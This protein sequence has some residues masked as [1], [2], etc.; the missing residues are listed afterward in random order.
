MI[1]QINIFGNFY[2]IL[3]YPDVNLW[4]KVSHED[5]HYLDYFDKLRIEN[6]NIAVWAYRKGGKRDA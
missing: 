6:C 3:G 2:L 1:K 5:G 4:V